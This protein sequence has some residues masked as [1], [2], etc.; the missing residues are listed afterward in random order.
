MFRSLKLLVCEA[1]VLSIIFAPAISRAAQ[2]VP[3][4]GPA[5]PV[6]SP[7][8]HTVR[9]RFASQGSFC[10]RVAVAG[11]STRNAP[12]AGHSTTGGP[13]DL[14][15]DVAP[16]SILWA[17]LYW[18]ILAEEPPMNGV[19][20]NGELVT[21]VAL[22]VGP[23]LCWNDSETY[24]Y[25]AD[26]TGIATPGTNIVAG[27]DDSGE[28]GI[29][30]ESEGASLVVV[31]A[32]EDN[33]AREI[34]IM[35]GNDVVTTCG[36][37]FDNAIPVTSPSGLSANLYF[38]GADGQTGPEYPFADDNQL[39][40]GAALGDG[41]DFDASDPASPGASPGVGW[42]S[43]AQPSGWPVVTGGGNTA[44]VNTLCALAG[45]CVAWVATVIEVNVRQCGSSTAVDPTTWG[46][47]KGLFR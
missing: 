15:P 8:S 33:E 31:Y 35:D 7:S 18:T 3:L 23:S 22:P 11:V 46:R 42:D 17:G 39:W 6:S 36:Q 44:S 14:P 47:V 28:L 16:G 43:D 38:I 9:A 21:P 2:G 45:D 26:V 34:I 32:S 25:F 20:L 4:T 29:P 27:L 10:V 30:P 5:S 13:I 41:D 12:S 24:S 37:Q 19:N 1:A 40:N